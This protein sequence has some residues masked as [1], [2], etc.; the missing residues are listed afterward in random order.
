M[1]RDFSLWVR[2]SCR[3]VDPM[4]NHKKSDRMTLPTVKNEITANHIQ[5]N[6]MAK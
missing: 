6:S 1:I 4:L 5:I 2:P 3:Y